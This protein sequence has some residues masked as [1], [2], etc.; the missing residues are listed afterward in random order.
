M[1]KKA[2]EIAKA[3]GLK[4]FLFTVGRMSNE[5]QQYIE[6]EGKSFWYRTDNTDWSVLRIKFDNNDSQVTRGFG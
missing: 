2:I 4:N 6:R 1:I 3:E 5:M